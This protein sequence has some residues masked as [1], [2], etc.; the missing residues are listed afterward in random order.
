MDM[1]ESGALDA[2]WINFFVLD[3]VDRMLDMG[4]IDD[5]KK[6]YNA[7]PRI[8]HVMTFSAT[9]TRE[10]RR[11]VDSMVKNETTEI[12]IDPAPVAHKIDHA[13]MDVPHHDKL[14]TTKG[15]LDVHEDDKVVIFTQTKSNTAAVAEILQK[16]GYRV[17][18]LHGDMDQRDRMKTLKN[19]KN[20]DHRVLV[21]TD[22]AAR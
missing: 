4:F 18:A 11:V 9:M 2:S 7:L 22:V 15:L 1:L 20:N 16:N 21:A 12:V 5:V 3:E 14:S 13:Y 17:C 10:V 19:F 8:D 6:I